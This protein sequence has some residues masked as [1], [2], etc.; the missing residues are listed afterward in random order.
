MK[1]IKYVASN[2][3]LADVNNTKTL[4]VIVGNT[5]A[6][7]K[8]GK[9]LHL[10]GTPVGGNVFADETASVKPDDT[11][12]VGVLLHDVIFEG[13][14]TQANGTLLYFGTVNEYRLDADLTIAAT[15]KTALDGKVTFVKRNK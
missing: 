12:P 9:K 11:T 13:E 3:I 10:A 5:G 2:Q 7:E 14:E 6:K 15:A 1:K 4:S 8:D